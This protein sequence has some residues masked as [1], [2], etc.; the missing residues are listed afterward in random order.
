ML[1]A[2]MFQ[3]MDKIA[4]GDAAIMGI[5][6]DLVRLNVFLF[7]PT[8]ANAHLESRRKSVLVGI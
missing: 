5:R 1:G 8:I 2:Y 4:L 6:E 7:H 3:F